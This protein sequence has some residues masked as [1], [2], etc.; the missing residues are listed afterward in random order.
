MLRNILNQLKE[1][2]SDSEIIKRAK[3]KYKLPLN[4]KQFKNYIKTN[5]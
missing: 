4:F 2:K 5:I 3:G 1:S